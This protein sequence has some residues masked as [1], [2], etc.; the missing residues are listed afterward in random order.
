MTDPVPPITVKIG[1]PS[2]FTD[3]DFSAMLKQRKI[4][5][6]DTLHWQLPDYDGSDEER[7]TFDSPNTIYVGVYYGERLVYSA[8]LLPRDK[9]MVALLWPHMLSLIPE[10]ASIEI[11][12]FVGHEQVP[13]DVPARAIRA[14]EQDMRDKE[15]DN[16]FAVADRGVLLFYRRILKFPPHSVMPFSD[17][18]GVSLVQWSL[19]RKHDA[20]GLD[21]GGRPIPEGGDSNA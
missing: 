11:S 9:S 2:D 13:S 18:E 4:A 14:F 19:D 15:V 6:I 8:R 16:L 12:R 3:D 7:D 17:L 1:L 5:F 10:G 21:D 20:A